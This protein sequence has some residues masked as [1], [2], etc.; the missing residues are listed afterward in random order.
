MIQFYF[1]FEIEDE[2]SIPYNYWL[3]DR[4]EDTHNELINAKI[5]A[6]SFY[7]PITKLD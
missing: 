2:V 5:Q 7:K 3:I 1:E 6:G 4:F